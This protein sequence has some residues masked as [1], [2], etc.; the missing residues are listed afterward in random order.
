MKLQ[1]KIYK[2][3]EPL[4]LKQ[5]HRTETFLNFSN[6][7][8]LLVVVILSAQ[9][10]DEGVNAISP[11]LFQRF[12]DPASM[13]KARIADIIPYVRHVNYFNSKARYLKQTAEILMRDFQGIVPDTAEDLMKLSGVGRKTAVA[14]LANGFNKYVGIAV[15]THVIR[16][17]HRFSLSSH[18]D[19][20]KIE[21]DLLQIIPQKNWNAVSYA[22]K[23]YGRKEG[24]ARNYDPT[25][26]PLMQAVLHLLVQKSQ[27]RYTDTRMAKR[28]SQDIKNK[29]SRSKKTKKR[30]A[31]KYAVK[32]ARGA[33][34]KTTKK[35]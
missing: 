33:K 28:I 19:P 1:E 26:D 35:K 3:L 18:T 16:F 30:V 27:T 24:R 11:K 23:E 31:T 34:K 4:L 21:Q 5:Y 6:P 17:A 9:M 22:I 7:W 29:T 25:T 14:V 2:T 15:D 32:A 10:T 12:P 8:E 20:N 13:A